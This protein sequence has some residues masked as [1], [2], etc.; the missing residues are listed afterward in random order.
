MEH[1]QVERKQKQPEPY[2]IGIF[3]CVLYLF[4]M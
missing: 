1:K 3:A 4:M 2:N